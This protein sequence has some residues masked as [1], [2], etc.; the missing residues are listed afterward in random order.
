M[1]RAV[2]VL[3]FAGLVALQASA[4][5]LAQPP[6]EQPHVAAAK[7]RQEAT[8]S[9]AMEFRVVEVV[10]PGGISE[11]LPKQLLG[12]KQRLVPEKATTLESVNRVI[13]FG[14]KVRYECN[15]PVWAPETGELHK[16][17]R[18]LTSDGAYGKTLYPGGISNP[19]QPEGYIDRSSHV[20]EIRSHTL[21]PFTLCVRGAESSISPYLITD[22]KATGAKTDVRGKECIECVRTTGGTDTVR[23]W[24]DPTTDYVPRRIRREVR[25]KPRHQTDVEYRQDPTGTYLPSSWTRLEYSAD[26]RVLTNTKVEVVSIQVGANHPDSDFDI[27]FPEKTKLYNARERKDYIVQADGSLREY[28]LAM[29][30]YTGTTAPAP[31]STWWDRNWKWLIATVVVLALLMSYGFRL[32]SRKVQ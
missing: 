8:N 3:L 15:H 9:I 18:I 11:P 1:Q 20:D 19:E 10:S 4:L 24:F 7:K 21:V 5:A 13:L 22:F 14:I 2:R 31:G 26:G 30:E 6:G 29:G 23:A 27:K 28:D 32:R 25:G 12:G 16:A 17:A